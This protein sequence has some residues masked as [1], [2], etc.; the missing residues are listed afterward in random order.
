MDLREEIKSVELEQFGTFT[1]FA[2]ERWDEYFSIPLK[3]IIHQPDKLTG[4][5]LCQLMS[6]GIRQAVYAETLERVECKYP[7]DWWEAVKERWLPA[8]AKRRWPVRYKHV[9]LT[10]KCYY[11]K[12]SKPDETHRLHLGKWESE[13]KRAKDR[14]WWED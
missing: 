8:W 1:C 10:A 14:E 12:I 13:D 11:P 5:P 2:E 4:D 7:V 6:V 9:A 3:V